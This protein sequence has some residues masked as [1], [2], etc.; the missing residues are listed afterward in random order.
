MAFLIGSEM[1]LALHKYLSSTLVP[2][3]GTI[4]T[5]NVLKMLAIWFSFI[6]NF[7]SSFNATRVFDL[8]LFGKRGFMIPQNLLLTAIFLVSKFS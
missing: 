5:Q 3:F 7:W 1:L 6:I 8:T 4:S 2:R